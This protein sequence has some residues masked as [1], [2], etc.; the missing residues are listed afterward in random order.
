MI[1]T[2]FPLMDEILAPWTEAIG[3]NFEGYRNHV[4]RTLN[5]CYILKKCSTDEKQ[6]LEIA[7][8]FHDIGVWT[9][10]T[11]T[12]LEPS[13]QRAKEWLSK[14]GL[15]H[16]QEEISLIIFYHHKI[17]RYKN[18]NYPLV[19]L[20]RKADLIDASLGTWTFSVGKSRYNKTISV[21][22]INFFF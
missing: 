3:P 13:I 2:S 12:Y 7:A 1:Q 20:F 22:P 18:P 21:L 9:D 11:F 5:F 14:N 16:W 6:K 19:E 10:H 8:A 17:T 15:I 4:Y